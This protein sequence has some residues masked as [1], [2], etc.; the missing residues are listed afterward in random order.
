MSM[1]WIGW[2][3]RH[4]RRKLPTVGYKILHKTTNHAEYRSETAVV[5][6][7]V[8]QDESVQHVVATYPTEAFSGGRTDQ[9]GAMSIISNQLLASADFVTSLTIDSFWFVLL[10]FYGDFNADRVL[11]ARCYK[12]TP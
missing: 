1:T 5:L 10:S 2:G 3:C 11:S 8:A 7:L 9:E 4:I 6:D 12:F